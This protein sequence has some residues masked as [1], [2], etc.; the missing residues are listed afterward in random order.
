MSVICGILVRVPRMPSVS[1]V[2]LLVDDVA[3]LYLIG[4]DILDMRCSQFNCE[5]ILLYSSAS[6]SAS[7]GGNRNEME[8]VT[9]VRT[10]QWRSS[11]VGFVCRSSKIYLD[12]HVSF[13]FCHRAVH[14]I[15]PPGSLRLSFYLHWNE[16]WRFL[17]DHSFSC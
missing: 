13:F 1:G 6:S 12:V 8:R 15:C 11:F 7:A 2:R 10:G 9:E 14:S 4:N 16:Q 3:L 5:K 17:S